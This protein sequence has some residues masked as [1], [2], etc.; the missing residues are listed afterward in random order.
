MIRAVPVGAAI[1]G[2]VGALGLVA[3][4]SQRRAPHVQS[5]RGVPGLL[6]NLGAATIIVYFALAVYVLVVAGFRGQGGRPSRPRSQW[7]SMAGLV[8]FV[9]LASF[10]LTK[11]RRTDAQNVK[12]LVNSSR[13]AR[14]PGPLPR[15]AAQ[16]P[17]T[18]GLQLGVGLVLLIVAVA[19]FL[20]VRDRRARGAPVPSTDRRALVAVS[21]GDLLSELNQEQDPRRAVLLADHGMEVALAEHGLPRTHAETANEYAQRVV[22]DLALSNAAAQTLTHLYGLAHFSASELTAKD[23]ESAVGALQS[24][25]DELRA[26]PLTEVDP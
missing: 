26:K 9:L 22:A 2:T 7:Q 24:V 4:G 25:R 12:E 3:L 6:K 17:V 13:F 16:R 8:I 10:F 14:E 23:R 21:L 15:A 18:W 5:G 19:V 20:A 1:V 11:F